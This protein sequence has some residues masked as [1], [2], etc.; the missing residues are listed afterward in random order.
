MVTQKELYQVAKKRTQM[1]LLQMIHP[2]LKVSKFS[3]FK[4][5]LDLDIDIAKI[6]QKFIA[7][8][9]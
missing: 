1:I 4:L 9:T 7:I 5:Y 8:I 3:L 6:K 2:F